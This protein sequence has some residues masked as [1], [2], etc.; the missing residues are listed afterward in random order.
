[1][2][3][4]IYEPD[5][6][7]HRLNFVRMMAP[8]LGELA[9]E[10]V[11]TLSCDAPQSAEFRENLR[12]IPGIR[13]DAATPKLEG[14]SSSIAWAKLRS[15]R[16][17]IVRNRPDHVYIPYGDGLAQLLGLP[18]TWRWANPS[19]VP[20]EVLLLR[21]GFAY[22]HP[23]VARRFSLRAG[24]KLA[25]RA[26]WYRLYHLDPLVMEYERARGGRSRLQ[27]MPEAVEAPPP[28][29][30]RAAALAGLG[31]PA[32]GRYIGTAGARH[33]SGTELLIRAFAAA[34]LAQ[35]HRLLLIGRLSDEL[36]TLLADDF[37]Q[38]VEQQRI[39]TVDRFVSSREF[40]EGIAAMDVA[41]VPYV[42]H[43]GSSS[44]VI[45]A[46]A[47]GRPVLA[48]DFG[49]CGKL[50]PMLGLGRTVEIENKAA[51]SQAIAESLAESDAFVPT[52]RAQRFAR[53]HSPQN[54]R[55]TWA[56]GLRQ[57]LGA[58]PAQ[59]TY[60]WEWVLEGDAA[61]LLRKMA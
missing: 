59:E 25:S 15:L 7:G 60:T 41:C 11:V 19:N 26:P 45:R 33:G 8:A 24:W 29:F 1:M 18:G 23:D 5:C 35:D 57:R 20:M 37:R 13:I 32:D 49:W 9:E 2:K 56:Q 30:N 53:F 39:C 44:I 22:P 12:D 34:P 14:S 3:V 61:L 54:F 58:Q 50:V 42:R 38:L 55:N 47:A 46:A 6:F 52:E 10:V 31:V 17:A 40:V 4:L 27:L 48:S 51:F 21:G 16:S 28:D 36:R 43:I